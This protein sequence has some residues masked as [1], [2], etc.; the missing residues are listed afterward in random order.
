VIYDESR[1]YDFRGELERM[2]SME[3]EARYG[4]PGQ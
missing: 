2:V 4:G 1:I 3:R